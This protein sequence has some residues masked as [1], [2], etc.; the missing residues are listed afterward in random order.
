MSKLIKLHAP[1]NAGQNVRYSEIGVYKF[2][3]SGYLELPEEEANI[4]LNSKFSFQFN[5][6]IDPSLEA[7]E[8]KEEEILESEIKEEIL[9]EQEI[10]VAERPIQ[11]KETL[12]KEEL[13]SEIEEKKNDD[14]LIEDKKEGPNP[15]PEKEVVAEDG[16]EDESIDLSKLTL[17]ELKAAAAD[18]GLPEAEFK[19]I[20]SKKEMIEYISP[21][22]ND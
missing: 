19:S 6:I 13:K 4:L 5:S 9:I 14:D 17:K 3:V 10:F 21:K 11:E 7:I 12:V 20:V 15:K 1:L 8:Q 16:K 18:A 22:L 2:D